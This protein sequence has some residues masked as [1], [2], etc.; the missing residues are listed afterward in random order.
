MREVVISQTVLDKIDDLEY[1][2]KTELKLSKEAAK[3]RCDRMETLFQSFELF[4]DGIIVRDMS[5]A[6]LLKD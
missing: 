3:C 6:K 4:D 1:F 5:H 2:L